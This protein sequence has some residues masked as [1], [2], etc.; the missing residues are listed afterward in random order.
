MVGIFYFKVP[1]ITLKVKKLHKNK[2]RKTKPARLK[3]QQGKGSHRTAHLKYCSVQPS[4]EDDKG[5]DKSPLL[6]A[7]VDDLTSST[8]GDDRAASKLL[9]ALLPFRTVCILSPLSFHPE[10]FVLPCRALNYP[11]THR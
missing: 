5:K 9:F 2:K 8:L 1:G 3:N 11:C 4:K 7:A 10:L 6:Y